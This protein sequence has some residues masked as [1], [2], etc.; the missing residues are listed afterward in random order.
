[1][2][3]D[4]LQ[5]YVDFAIAA[6]AGAGAAILPHFR[7]AV[8]VDNKSDAGFDP[9]TAAD[10][11]A[12]KSI[13]ARIAATFPDHGV[14]GEEYGKTAGS[15]PLHWLIDPIDGTRAFITGQLHWGTLLALNDGERPIVGVMHQPFVGE[16]FV[17][18]PLGAEWRRGT[19]TM[20][21]QTRRCQR[22]ADAVLCTT[23]PAMFA[24]QEQRDAF[25]RVAGECRLVRYGGD[26]YTPC[27]LAAGQ[28]D[29]VIESGLKNFDIQPLMPIV[30]H[31]GG[32]VTDWRGGRADA[33]GD[34]VV[35]GDPDLLNRV[36]DLLQTTGSGR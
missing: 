22:L 2:I 17:G 16:T 21:L 8:A 18:S 15:S 27:L 32:V 23:D 3:G 33:G 1:M 31:A 6:A 30:E 19:D 36:L 28:I 13:R 4:D 26:C 34:V 25:G 24:T 29:L 7:L 11:D 12:E 35:A 14:I 10:R 9:V 20:P 5:R